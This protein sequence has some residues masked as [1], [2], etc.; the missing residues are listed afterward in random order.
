MKN[1][2]SYFLRSVEES[3]GFKP[4]I[5]GQDG[6]RVKAALTH[7]DED[8]LKRM[9]DFFLQ[10]EK[11]DKVGITLSIALSAHSVNAFLQAQKRTPPPSDPATYFQGGH[12]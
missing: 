5:S 11:A 6:K 7:H 1:L 3:R 4:E 10:S 12:P 8:T 2:V 9:V